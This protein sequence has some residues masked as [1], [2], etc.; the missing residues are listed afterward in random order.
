MK[1]GAHGCRSLDGRRHGHLVAETV[2]M[3]AHRLGL[4]CL[5]LLAG[6]LC[7][8][9]A[10]GEGPVAPAV[11]CCP[12][13]PVPGVAWWAVPSDTGHYV[14]YYVGGGCLWRGDAP[15][16]DQGT[17]GW[18]YAACSF[19]PRIKLLWCRCEG[20]RANVPV[21]R[22]VGPKPHHSPSSP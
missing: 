11:S 7:P 22:T 12:A 18:D 10:L 21:Y 4:S 6:S 3:N 16:P 15:T 14:G 9:T 13:R 2:A 17:W 20:G 5:I 1:D 8:A 19:L